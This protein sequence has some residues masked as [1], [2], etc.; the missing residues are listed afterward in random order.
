[1][2]ARDPLPHPTG[3]RIDCRPDEV[4]DRLDHRL[5]EQVHHP[6]TV[7]KPTNERKEWLMCEPLGESHTY[8]TL[9]RKESR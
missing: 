1:M 6:H 5:H 2:T 7:R 4:H 8:I 3:G 9:T